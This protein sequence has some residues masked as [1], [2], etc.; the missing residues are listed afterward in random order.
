LY[1]GTRRVQLSGGTTHTV[2]I[3]KYRAKEHG[4]EAGSVLGISPRGDGSLL[5]DARRDTET[6]DRTAEV[7]VST[8]GESG[9]RRRLNAA[10]I[11]GVEAAT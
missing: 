4:T 8:D 3:P 10:C 11:V 5:V 1:A 6:V 2:P 7:D 9:I